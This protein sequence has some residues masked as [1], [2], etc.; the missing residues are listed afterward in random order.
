MQEEKAS[1][2]EGIQEFVFP[3]MKKKQEKPAEQPAESAPIEVPEPQPAPAPE[4]PLSPDTPPASRVQSEPVN[5]EAR[6]IVREVVKQETE[7][8][9]LSSGVSGF[10]EISEGGIPAGSVVLVEGPSGS[11]KTTLGFNFLVEGIMRGE[12][13]CFISLRSS[14][15]ELGAAMRPFN[16]GL[17]G[18]VRD[19]N[20]LIEKIEVRDMGS[21]LDGIAE[22]VSLVNAKRLVIDSFSLISLN[23]Q[24][25][26]RVKKAE[27]DFEK[28]V[29]KLGCTTLVLLDS[30][31]AV[32]GLTE[33]IES[34][35]DGVIELLLDKK[36]GVLR[37]GIS[38]KKMRA[39]NHSLAT[40]AFGMEAGKGAI[41]FSGEHIL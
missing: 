40:H 39:T 4:Q 23:M 10:D 36:G 6:E 41:V 2:E 5:E 22:S 31:N 26:G 34:G 29:K 33:M 20:L 15:Q 35:S 19:K 14:R 21:F 17:E 30:H 3:E 12:N 32:Q 27:F 16:W 28:F 9:R 24:G 7:F 37:R 11:G 1:E 18:F 8:R 38:I 13:G 25:I